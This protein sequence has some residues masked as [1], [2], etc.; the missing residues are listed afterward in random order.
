[1]IIK[2]SSSSV[3][4]VPQTQTEKSQLSICQLQPGSNNSVMSYFLNFQAAFVNF[5]LVMFETL[6]LTANLIVIKAKLTRRY[7]F[8]R[9]VQKPVETVFSVFFFFLVLISQSHSKL[10]RHG[11]DV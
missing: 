10:Y 9:W 4:A 5:K 7:T 11:T 1:M 3:R 2:N 6:Y 8:L